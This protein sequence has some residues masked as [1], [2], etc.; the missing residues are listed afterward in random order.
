MGRILL[1]EGREAEVFVGD[2]TRT[3][4]KLLRD[5]AQGDRV[6]REVAALRRVECTFG[7]DDVD[8]VRRRVEAA[9]GRILMERFTISG[10]GHLVAFADPGGNPVLAMEYDPSAE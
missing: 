5:P 7:V 6:A 9:G 3:V 2:D 10:V 1:A 4:L 8:D